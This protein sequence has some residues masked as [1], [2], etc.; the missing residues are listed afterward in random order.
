[1]EINK[2]QFAH[3][4][5]VFSNI[6]EDFIMGIDFFIKYGLGYD[7]GSLK[8]YWTDKSENR[9]NVA[10]L[11]CAEK[12]TIEPTSTKIVTLNVITNR[13]FRVA[14]AGDA[15]A[16]VSSKEHVVQGGPA[17]VRV[18]KLGQVV[19]EIFNCTNSMMTIEKDTALGIIENIHANEDSVGELNVNNLTAQLEELEPNEQKPLSAEKKKY[20]LENAQLNVPEEFEV[21]IQ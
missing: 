20:I 12:I 15:V 21:K 8:L 19:M 11:H 2:K 10:D 4:V 17:L 7:L 14:E 16:V 1:M 3:E 6:N 18:K 13:G 5:P 9:W